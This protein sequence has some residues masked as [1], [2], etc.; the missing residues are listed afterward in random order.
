MRMRKL[1]MLITSVRSVKMQLNLSGM[2]I[3]QY[4]K[5]NNMALINIMADIIRMLK[6]LM[7]L[8]SA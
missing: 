4:L 6:F 1:L 2:F 8:T 5:G 7:L 3:R